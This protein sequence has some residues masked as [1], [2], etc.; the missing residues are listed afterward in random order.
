VGAL[1]A[2]ISHWNEVRMEVAACATGWGEQESDQR[3]RWTHSEGG[4][5]GM[6]ISP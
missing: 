1:R 5:R 3:E 2:D 4:E 6:G